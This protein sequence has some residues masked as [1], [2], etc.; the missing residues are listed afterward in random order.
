LTAIPFSEV[1]KAIEEQAKRG[2]TVGMDQ[3]VS[4]LLKEFDRF[5]AFVAKGYKE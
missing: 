5:K 4:K 2:E 1:A 3:L